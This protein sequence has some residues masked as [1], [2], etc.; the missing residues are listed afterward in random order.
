MKTNK[1]TVLVCILTLVVVSI[2]LFGCGEKQESQSPASE[3]SAKTPKI[4][5]LMPS[6]SGQVYVSLV[7][8]ILDEA[9]KMGLEQPIV[10]SAGGYDHLD[11]QVKQVEDLMVAGV[12]AIAIMPLAEEGMTPV[13]DRAVDAGII[14]LETGNTTTSEKVQARVRTDDRQIG[15]KLGEACVKSLNGKGNVVMFNGPAGASWSILQTEGFKS[16]VDNYPDIK[17]LAEK[18]IVYDAGVAMNT[19]NDLLQ[20]FPDIDYVYTA[21]DTYAEG[22]ASALEAAGLTGKIKVGTASLT[23]ATLEMLKTGSLDYVVGTT[24]VLEGRMVLQTILKLYNGEEV[25]PLQFH[26]LEDFYA[27]DVNSPNLDTSNEF[28]PEGWTVPK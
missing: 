23:T 16:V 12:D 24:T 19:M 28:F 26:L 9:E 14:V 10:L 1:W 21:Y 5:V 22:A 25:P 8:G 18:W 6:L 7:Y 11:A 17:I 2:G 15:V 20:A 3:Q 27:A 4:A 13:L